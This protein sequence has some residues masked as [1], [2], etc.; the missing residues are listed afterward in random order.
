MTSVAKGILFVFAILA[1]TG[2]VV[3]A[4]DVAGIQTA[5][6]SRHEMGPHEQLFRETCSKV[7]GTTVWN[8]RNWECLK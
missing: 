2:I 3:F 5:S 6:N 7:G 8:K 4:L 1:A